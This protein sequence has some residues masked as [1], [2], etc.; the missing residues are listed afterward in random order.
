MFLFVF[1]AFKIIYK[2]KERSK[3]MGNS[4]RN[5]L[6]KWRLFSVKLIFEYIIT[7][8]PDT[9]LINKNYS[10]G[11]K[12]YEESIILVKA[13]SFDHAYKI[14]EKK[15]AE[16]DLNHFNPYGEWVEYKFV[17]AIDC[18]CIGDESMKTGTELYSRFIRVKKE[19]GSE[20][21]LDMYFPDTIKENEEIDYKYILGFREI[22]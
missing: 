15:A 2:I 5:K 14:A 22:D 18:F 13:Q 21:F 10:N 11:S 7:G 6:S 17:E 20:E 1:L 9:E 12:F 16:I 19:L 8:E 3:K 4:K